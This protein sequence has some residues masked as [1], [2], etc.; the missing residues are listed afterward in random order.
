[1]RDRLRPR[2][3]PRRGLPPADAGRSVWPR[4][5][6]QLTILVIGFTVVVALL[7][8]VVVNASRVF[9]VHRA[10]SAAA[11]GAA[12][13]A[14]DALDEPRFYTGSRPPDTL[15]LSSAAVAAA[16]EDY[17]AS[18]GLAERFDGFR[19]G[20]TLAPDGSTVSA[21]CAAVVRLPFVNLV[22]QRYADGLPLSVTASA[23]SPLQR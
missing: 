2:C 14:A 3:G 18:A 12:V 8:T 5:A 6:G 23:R 15:P 13:A 11:D 21:T 22:S 7:I 9:L 19:A 10:L 20:G 4:D 17:A 16:V 1:M